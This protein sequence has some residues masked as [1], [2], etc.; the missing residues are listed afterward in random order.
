MRIYPDFPLV[1]SPGISAEDQ[2]KLFE[3]YS[4]VT[5]GWVQKA[6]VSGLGLSMA[7]RFVER[8]GGSI[9]VES[10]EG[11]GST[12]FFSIPFPLIPIDVENEREGSKADSGL[13]VL[14]KS[15]V[16][17]SMSSSGVTVMHESITLSRRRSS[18]G[19]KEDSKPAAKVQSTKNADG[20]KDCAAMRQRKVLL[21]EDTRINRVSFTAALRLAFG[22]MSC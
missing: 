17:Q 4:F 6:G 8:A 18:T 10:E 9:G 3:P 5:S 15:E 19:V 2:A 12:F 1:S 21:V 13:P 16:I 20:A 11:R 7:K 14:Q 22:H